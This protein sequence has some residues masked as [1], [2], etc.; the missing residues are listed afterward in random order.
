[1]IKCL[2]FDLDGVIFLT[3]RLQLA[4]LNKALLA[5]KTNLQISEEDDMK[6]YG[7]VPSKDK[8]KIL[9]KLQ[10]LPEEKHQD[11]LDLKKKFITETMDIL[12]LEQFFPSNVKECIEKL[13]QEYT[14]YIASN[15]NYNF[16]SHALMRAGI[17]GYFTKIFCGSDV[18]HPKPNPEMYLKVFIDAGVAPSDCLI[19]EDSISGQEAAV[20]SGA[21]VYGV[22]SPKDLNYDKIKQKINAIKPEPIKWCSEKINV[23]IPMAGEGQRFKDEG[24]TTPKP[25]IDV[26][27]LP[28]VGL[29]AHKLDINANFIFVVR[30]EH[31]EQ[32]NLE[33]ILKLM[34]PTCTI[35]KTWGKQGGAACSILKAEQFINN[36]EHL[37][38]VNSDQIWD[39]NA[40]LFY[41][42]MVKQELDG[43]IV[44]FQDEERNPKW[45]FAKTDKEGYVT[46]VAEKTPI[47]DL[48]TAGIYYFKSGSD[49]VKYAKQMIEK[50]IT[51]NN[52]YYTAP[53]YNELIQDGK[54]IKTFMI[55]KMIG[56][57][58]PSDLMN[59]LNRNKQ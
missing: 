40:R 31:C 43:G 24:F 55:D 25:I 1:M 6:Y 57:G 5:A 59:Y 2:I 51:V 58:I 54:K 21:Y 52:E 44:V 42:Q 32:Y 49:F 23:V 20:K 15:T 56:L 16:I 38:I 13:S 36:N 46:E 50:K 22:E 53:V 10:G 37:L 9:S 19:F 48:G 11:I 47:S 30:G 29:V 3:E 18:K 4:A 17:R 7:T 34:H 39:W 27:G 12:P 8:L 35:V 14:L 33:T 26:E 41:S 45:S 28:M